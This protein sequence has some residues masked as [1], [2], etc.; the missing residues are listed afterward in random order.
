MRSV[1]FIHVHVATMYSQIYLGQSQVYYTF[2]ILSNTKRKKRPFEMIR[3]IWIKIKTLLLG[4]T[5]SRVG[6][7][8]RI[9]HNNLHKVN[10][11]S[12]CYYINQITFF[13]KHLICYPVYQK[14]CFT[15]SL[16]F[17]KC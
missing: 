13:R 11:Y 7:R 8:I 12:C 9:L 17:L 10:L 15:P 3:H 16:G 6:L 4:S 1:S 2:E 14:M 5:V